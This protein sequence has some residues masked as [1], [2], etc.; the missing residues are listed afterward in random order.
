MPMPDRPPLEITARVAG[1]CQC[2][3]TRYEP[4]VKLRQEHGRWVLIEHDMPEQPRAQR[5][6]LHDQFP[7]GRRDR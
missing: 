4:G 6:G 1:R 5:P 3:N 2:C 7:M